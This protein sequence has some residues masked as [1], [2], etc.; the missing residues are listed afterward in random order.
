MREQK[1]LGEDV[2]AVREGIIG[3]G[4]LLDRLVAIEARVDWC[5]EQIHIID[6]D[7]SEALKQ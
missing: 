7:R 1:K 5:V 4:N 3:T 2:G 6:K